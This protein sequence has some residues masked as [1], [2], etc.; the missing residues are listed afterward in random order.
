MVV[1]KCKLLDCA[2]SAATWGTSLGRKRLWGGLR[3]ELGLEGIGVRIREGGVGCGVGLEF[4]LGLGLKLG[5]GLA[6]KFGRVCVGVGVRES[7]G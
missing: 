4:G 7:C 5:F 1:V 3:L 2:Y 6:L